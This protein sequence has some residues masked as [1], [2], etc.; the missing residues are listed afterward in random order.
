MGGIR[1]FSSIYIEDFKKLSGAII[2]LELE[3]YSTVPY[4]KLLELLNNFLA[5]ALV[6]GAN[7]YH[8]GAKVGEYEFK[9]EPDASGGPDMVELITGPM[10][11]SDARLVLT[12]A[13]EFIRK[14]GKT[15]Q[16]CSVHVNVSYSTETGLDMADV[17]KLALILDFD[18]EF[19]YE[20]FPERRA[21]IYAK[22]VKDIIPFKDFDDFRTAAG[23]IA[24]NVKL[25]EETKYYGINLAGID[26][27][28][29]EYRYI[30][31]DYI[32]KTSEVMDIFDYCVAQTMDVAKKP[33]TDEHKTKLINYMSD[34]MGIYSKF[35]SYDAFLGSAAGVTLSIDNVNDYDV[36]SAHYNKFSETLYQIFSSGKLFAEEGEIL[37]MNYDSEAKVLQLLGAT[38][39][40]V[41]VEHV[42]FIDCQL[43]NIML[44][45]CELVDCNADLGHFQNCKLYET[46]VSD[47]K[48]IQSEVSKNSIMTNCFFDGGTILDAEMIGGVLRSANVT[49]DAEISDTTV[50]HDDEGFW[51]PTGAD[52]KKK[53]PTIKK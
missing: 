49:I 2:G 27:G 53:K 32:K 45:E 3:F 5:P 48:I 51:Q 15:D 26:R 19:V 29:V 28:W 44:N 34:K 30:G 38:V 21:N 11:Y 31:G 22:S 46:K 36:V 1:T 47:S 12:K 23:V 16:R 33:V 18:E 8:S 14:Y 4:Y 10:P 20:K 25:P 13:L 40:D 39:T 7:A 42:D 6:K 17:N 37:R 35:K 24:Q 50:T 9:I 52:N 43:S 41:S